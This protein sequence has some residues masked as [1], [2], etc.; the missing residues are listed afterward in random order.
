M[1]NFV[2]KMRRSG[3]V[4][5]S[6]EG[7]L[8]TGITTYY[9]KLRTDLH[10]GPPLNRRDE[11]ETVHNRRSKLGASERWFARRRGGQREVERKVNGWRESGQGRPM[12]P[13]TKGPRTCSGSH[14]A[15]DKPGTNARDK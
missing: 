4:Q 13:R 1:A 6:V 10:G 3:Y 7:I 5:E 2:V 11:T 15:Q 9:R 12:G 8:E 14:G